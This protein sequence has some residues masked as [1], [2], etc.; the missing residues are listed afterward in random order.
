MFSLMQGSRRPRFC[1]VDDT[2]G[3]GEFF[4]SCQ[5]RPIALKPRNRNGSLGVLYIDEAAEIAAA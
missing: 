5:R 3:V 1:P 2:A 4:E